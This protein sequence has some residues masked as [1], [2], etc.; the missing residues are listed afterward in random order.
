VVFAVIIALHWLAISRFGQPWW[1][2]HSYGPRFM[3]DVLP[4]LV[5]F[6]AFACK[7]S[8]VAEGG[9]AGIAGG[10]AL[11]AGVSVLM[12]AQ[13]AL[14]FEPYQWNGAPISI[15]RA[16]SR[17]WSWR[18]PPFAR[19][20][21]AGMHLIVERPGPLLN[22]TQGVVPA[23]V[24]PYQSG[25]A[26]RFQAD[27]RLDRAVLQSGW[28]EREKWGVWS[29]G[30]EAR[31]VLD[32]KPGE[33]L[34]GSGDWLLM[35]RARALVVPQRPQQVVD[36]VVNGTSVAV[37]TF[38]LGDGVLERRAPVLAALVRFPLVVTFRF[39]NAATL[40]ELGIMSGD[41]RRF[42]IGLTSLRLA[43]AGG[44]GEEL[45]TLRLVRP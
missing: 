39:S 1:G 3:T 16:P 18:D 11:L 36:V 40:G 25:L 20:V 37:W 21:I 10:V 22:L 14:N 5:Y 32:A 44:G 4:F 35:V 30:S 8:T 12:H 29:E 2:G 38:Q 13:G 7:P 45:T 26:V 19:G 41:E 6:V 34:M 17:L 31:L 43:P 42:G 28:S 9:R 33:R 15:D 24:R 27:S 23:D